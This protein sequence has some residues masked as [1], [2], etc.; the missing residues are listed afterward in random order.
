MYVWREVREIKTIE[1][2]FVET[3]SLKLRR[4]IY[5]CTLGVCFNSENLICLG[6]KIFIL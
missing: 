6:S 3:T 2:K 4:V 1:R 5:Y